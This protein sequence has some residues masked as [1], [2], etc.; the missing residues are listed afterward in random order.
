MKKWVQIIGILIIFSSTTLLAKGRDFGLGVIIG[1]PTG[2]SFKYW[3][4]AASAI[5]GA[6]AWSF[7]DESAFHLHADY[8]LHAFEVI[9]VSQG[10]LPLYY[11]IGVRLKLQKKDNMG[12]RIPFGIA[13]HFK[14]APLDVFFEIVPV[15][16]LIPS[17]EL[18]FNGAFGLR[19][20]F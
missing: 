3:N 17:T 12:I 4:D 9:K 20:Y 1:E 14:N 10:A 8:L 11:G 2:I 18:S 13:Y 19:Y 7:G 5:D 15:L 16:E 6:V